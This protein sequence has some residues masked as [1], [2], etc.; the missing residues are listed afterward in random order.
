MYKCILKIHRIHDSVQKLC[1]LIYKNSLENVV[2][3]ITVGASLPVSSGSW[4][5]LS[6]MSIKGR[7]TT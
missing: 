2:Y 5:N 3:V 6:A 4:D 1:F 7:K